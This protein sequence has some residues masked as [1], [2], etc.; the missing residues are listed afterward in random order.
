M[1]G[2]RKEAWKPA[3]FVEK[4]NAVAKKVYRFNFTI[5]DE[6]FGITQ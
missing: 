3:S 6:D 2:H 5:T 4:R 1:I